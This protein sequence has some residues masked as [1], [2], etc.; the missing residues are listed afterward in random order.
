MSYTPPLNKN[1]NSIERITSE[2]HCD[3]DRG[4]TFF[5]S[6]P[7]LCSNFEVPPSYFILPAV[8]I[9]KNNTTVIVDRYRP[10]IVDI[11]GNEVTL[12]SPDE[13]IS[14]PRKKRMWSLIIAIPGD[15]ILNRCA[16]AYD[17]TDL[18]I[19]LPKALER[20]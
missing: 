11:V 16:V 8:L 6:V 13:P 18:E 15:R 2:E 12:I 17:L 1:K 7:L 10:K 5:E 4:V 19:M 9:L 3:E 20:L 14:S